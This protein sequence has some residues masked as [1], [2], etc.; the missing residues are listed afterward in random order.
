[1]A[2]II[3]RDDE[4]PAQVARR[5]LD[6]AEHPDHVIWRLRSNT[7]PHGGVF[8]VP[9]AEVGALM[10]RVEAARAGASAAVERRIAAADERDEL[11]DRT[12][13]TPEE[14]GFTANASEDLESL[15]QAGGTEVEP[16]EDEV[17]AEEAAADAAAAA[18]VEEE[19]VAEDKAASTR[20]AARK[21]AAK[22]AAADKAAAEDPSATGADKE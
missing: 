14:L 8:E 7:P 15:G 2:E 13:L 6:Q 21:A 16:T 10:A 3:V 1:M 20:A 18:S 4:T 22:K 17:K 11:A 5:L 19:T 9:D 12:G